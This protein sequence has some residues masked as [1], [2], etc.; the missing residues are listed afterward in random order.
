[1]T[2]PTTIG[3][4]TLYQGDCL[5]ILPTLGKVDAVVTDPPYGI[6]FTQRTT[7]EKITGDDKPFD[8]APFLECGTEHIF[9]GANNFC[10]RLP[11]GRWLVWIKRAVEVAAPKSYGD[12][13]IAWVS[14]PGCIKAMRLISD[15]CIRQGVEHG[16]RR[17][18]P[19]QK[20]RE[21]MEWCL[22][23]VSGESILDPFMGSG[24]TGVACVKLGRK[25]IGIELEPK[26]F[27]IACE[28]IT[29]A[30]AQPDMFVPAPSKPVQEGMDL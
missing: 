7:G 22:E 21:I 4:C 26:Y 27:D 9:W 30:Y 19:S 3:D 23:F 25:F 28:R 24:T 13:E 10:Q 18:H 16:I 11:A 17:V 12:C 29:K 2:E 20:P 1:M 8:P 15:G 5:E 6:D 14:T